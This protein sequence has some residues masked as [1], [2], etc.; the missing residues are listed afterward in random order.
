VWIW[1]IFPRTLVVRVTL[2]FLKNTRPFFLEKPVFQGSSV[3]G[4]LFGVID[5]GQTV[6][7]PKVL[8]Q[9]NPAFG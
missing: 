1:L 5:T 6:D 7:K 8:P 3:I 2:G 4:L 9:L